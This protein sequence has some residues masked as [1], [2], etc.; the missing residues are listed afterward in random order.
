MSYRDDLGAAHV[1]IRV[2]E[3]ECERLRAAASPATPPLKREPMPHWRAVA[4]EFLIVVA[5]AFLEFLIVVA[6]AFI[7]MLIFWVLCFLNYTARP[8]AQKDNI[9]LFVR[10]W[11]S[12]LH[13]IGVS[14]P[15]VLLVGWG[16]V[17]AW[18]E[19]K[20]RVRDSHV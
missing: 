13:V 1:R 11:P 4:L 14:F 20:R 8:C 12:W 10:G 16:A 9:C 17:S 18:R 2:L 7:A 15:T 3:L 5:F 19:A 6:V